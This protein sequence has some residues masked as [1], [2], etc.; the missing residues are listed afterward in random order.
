VPGSGAILPAGLILLMRTISPTIRDVN[1]LSGFARWK[2][3][4]VC[5][6]GGPQLGR[7]G[8]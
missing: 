7:L 6:F 2:N 1:A 8:G 5:R 3:A 4:L